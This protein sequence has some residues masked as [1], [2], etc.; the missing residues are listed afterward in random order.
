MRISHDAVPLP[1]PGPPGRGRHR[2][3]PGRAAGGAERRDENHGHDGRA[4]ARASRGRSHS[5]RT[6]A[7]SSPSGRDGLRYVTREGALSDPIAGLPE[8]YA[9]GQGGLLDVILDPA[10]EKNSTIYFSYAEPAAGDTNGTAVARARLDGGRLADLKV[11]FRQQPKVASKQHFG[12]RLVFAR[13]GNLFVTTGERNSRACQGAGPVDA[14][15]QDPAHHAGRRRAAG[16]SLRRPQGRA[17]RNL[18]LRPPQ[19]AG[20][21]AEP[22][23]GPALGDRARPARRRRNQHSRGRQELRLAHHHLRAR[24][25]RPGDRRRHGEGGHGAA[26]PL[27]GA[28]HRAL[29]HDVSRRARLS[30]PGRGSFSSARSRPSSSCGSRSRRTARSTSE[31]RYAIGK[32]VRDV[33]EGPDG[34]LYLV[35]DEDAGEILRVVPA[36]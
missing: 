28:V 12:S 13:D 20:R 24:V 36:N 9:E 33:R 18:V 31:E 25:Q 32:R 23:H 14:P 11:I 15:R 34:A 6:G 30:R 26:D 5:C 17:A 22:G 19:L 8:V 1:A 21:D 10:F 27:L 3:L 29:R 16:Q 7:C 4:R 35:T 2:R